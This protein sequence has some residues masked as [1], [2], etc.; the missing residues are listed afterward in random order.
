M[1]TFRRPIALAALL[2]AAACQAK[3]KPPAA[4]PADAPKQTVE[5]AAADQARI[6]GRPTAPVWVVE[7]S[8]F[9]C[10]Y[11]KMWHDSTYETLKREY[12]NTGKVRLAY[13]NFPLE[14][15]RNAMPAAEA[16]MCAAAQGK[17]WEMHD[18]LF[19]AQAKW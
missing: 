12:V 10:P 9:Q 17:F 3:E 1:I 19:D 2:A 11:C 5:G 14:K 4:A 15:H 7:V 8:D 13:I 18:A 16:A 6:L